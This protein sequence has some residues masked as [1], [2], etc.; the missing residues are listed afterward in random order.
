MY[1][2]STKEFAKTKH[3]QH[4]SIWTGF[5]AESLEAFNRIFK[6]TLLFYN[7]IVYF[8]LLWAF[9][10]KWV[11]HSIYMCFFLILSNM[12]YSVVML[13]PKQPYKAESETR[14]IQRRG[15]LRLKTGFLFLL[16]YAIL[17]PKRARWHNLRLGNILKDRGSQFSLLTWQYGMSAIHFGINFFGIWSEFK[18]RNG[19]EE[20]LQNNYYHQATTVFLNLE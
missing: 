16:L 14:K 17:C 5:V 19:N 8:S 13:V 1:F 9:I 6:L 11:T 12:F 20:L 15:D 7:G 10:T 3:Y 18:D 2:Q 4:F